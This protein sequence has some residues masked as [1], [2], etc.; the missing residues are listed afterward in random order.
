MVVAKHPDHRPNGAQDIADQLVLVIVPAQRE[1]L[2]AV[3]R[4]KVAHDVGDVL[5]GD[6]AFAD[7]AHLVTPSWMFKWIA[8]RVAGPGA[9][10]TSSSP[11]CV[12]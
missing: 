4:A 5:L 2:G 7:A 1:D 3:A 9:L 10:H 12:P 8:A 11:K 6:R